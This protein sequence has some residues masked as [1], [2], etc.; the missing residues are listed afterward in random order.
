MITEDLIFT[1]LGV[2]AVANVAALSSMLWLIYRV[3]RAL[4]SGSDASS[5]AESTQVKAFLGGPGAW[6]PT[7]K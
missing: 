5:V 6:R 7:E 3:A 2:I 1:L 4:R